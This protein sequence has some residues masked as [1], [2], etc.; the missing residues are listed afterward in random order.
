MAILKPAPVIG[1]A[2]LSAACVLASTAAAQEPDPGVNAVKSAFLYNFTKFV[3][4]PESAF[5]PGAAPFRVCVFA[6]ASLRADIDGMLAGEAV[7]GRPVRVV[8]PPAAEA[9]GCHIAYFAGGESDKTAAQ[10]LA[11]AR[12]RPILLVGEGPSFLAQGGHISFVI[13]GNRVRFDVNRAE[14]ERAG[15]TISSKLLRVARRVQA[16]GRPL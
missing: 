2:L 10:V 1:A 13:E 4:W 9:R 8:T 15:L 6:G 3:E 11:A 14:I 7:G 5:P 12:S 16:G